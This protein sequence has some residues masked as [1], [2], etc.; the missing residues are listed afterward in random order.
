MEVS[1]K[2]SPSVLL[3]L[4]LTAL[5]PTFSL[6]ASLRSYCPECLTMALA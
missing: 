6:T 3:Y 1:F 4:I 2:K 5:V